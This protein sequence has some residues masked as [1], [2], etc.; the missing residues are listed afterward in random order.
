MTGRIKRWAIAVCLAAAFSVTAPSLSRA[1]DTAPPD[2][3]ARLDGYPQTMLL[4]A[5]GT[6]MTYI[7]MFLLGG[8]GLGVM[9]IS[10]K[11]TH[12]D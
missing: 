5:S 8:L 3:D 1:D 4:D 2:H 6:A 9:F 7:V 11:R 12:L 10:G